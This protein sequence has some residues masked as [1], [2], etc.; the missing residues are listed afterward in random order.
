M[1]VR[2]RLLAEGGLLSVVF[3]FS[4]PVPRQNI[5]VVNFSGIVIRFYR[6]AGT[7]RYLH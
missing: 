3:N 2:R 4:P 1:P 5:S 7:P 6:I